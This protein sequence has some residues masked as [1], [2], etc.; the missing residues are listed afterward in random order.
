MRRKYLDENVAALEVTLSKDDLA[1]VDAL[2]LSEK[3][4]RR[5]DSRLMRAQRLLP[6]ESEVLALLKIRARQ[7]KLHVAGAKRIL[8]CVVTLVDRPRRPKI[9]SSSERHHQTLVSIQSKMAGLVSGTGANRPA[10]QRILRRSITAFRNPGQG[11]L[12]AAKPEGQPQLIHI[13]GRL[14]RRPRL[15]EMSVN[16]RLH[17]SH[18]LTRMHRQMRGAILAAEASEGFAVPVKMAD[19]MRQK[20]VAGT[21][22]SARMRETS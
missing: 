12:A 18:L 6:V 4:P 7:A 1:R 11:F 21:G 17:E 20:F 22:R 16:E 10:A 15:R 19:Q 5:G 3:S 2:R 9:G 13:D 14:V 8:D